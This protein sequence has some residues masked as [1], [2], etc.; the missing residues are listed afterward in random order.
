MSSEKRGKMEESEVNPS[1]KRQGSLRRVLPPFTSVDAIGNANI[2]TS[3]AAKMIDRPALSSS[4]NRIDYPVGGNVRGVPFGVEQIVSQ[5][6]IIIS[7]YQ[8]FLKQRIPGMYAIPSAAS[9]YLWFGVLFMRQGLYREGVFRFQIKIPPSYPSGGIP[10]FIFETAIFHPMVDSQSG[11]LA[12]NESF[13]GKESEG[14]RW[15]FSERVGFGINERSHNSKHVWQVLQNAQSAMLKVE[16]DNPLNKEAAKMYKE[17][18]EE[19]AQKAAEAVKHS[20]DHIHDPPI[21]NDPHYFSFQHYDE[22]IHESYR[23]K[24]LKSLHRE[25]SDSSSSTVG[26]SWVEPGT[27]IPFSKKLSFS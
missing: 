6:Y 9:S 5:E 17:N 23:K 7:E 10:K 22:N 27:L 26:T 4:D 25:T 16:I 13:E 15:E 14:K 1:F 24:L 21:I 8:L 18:F 3:S 2:V 12:Y 19:F 11:E 20:V